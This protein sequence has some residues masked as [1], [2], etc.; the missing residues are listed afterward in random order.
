MKI[1]LTG[2]TGFIGNEILDQCLQHHY[3]HHVY[4]L[5][6]KHLDVKYTTHRK[7]TEVQLETFDDLPDHLFERLRGWGV[8]GC[9]WALGAKAQG[10]NQDEAERVGIKYPLQAAEGFAK[11]APDIME[12]QTGANI[13]PFRFVFMS[14]WGAESNQFRS[15]WMWSR[16]R[17]LKGAAETG[18]FDI[19]DE[20]KEVDGKKSFEVVALRPGSVLAKGEALS[21]IIAQGTMPCI[22][23]DQLANR[24]I[25]IVLDGDDEGRRVLENRDCF[26]EEWSQVNTLTI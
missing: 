22:A 13:K 7:V 5:T 21:T 12:T 23:V 11:M 6:R 14:G 2:A 4:V 10:K 3:I 19:A 26:K 18:L 24:A 16:W 1:V 20:S 15:L 8:Q 17:K 25:R 9:I